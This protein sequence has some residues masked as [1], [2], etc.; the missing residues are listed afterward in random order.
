MENTVLSN[1]EIKEE[2]LNNYNLV[3]LIVDDREFADKTYWKNSNTSKR[4]VKKVGAINSNWQLE[5]TSYGSQP[6]FA[7]LSSNN[8]VSTA[9]GFTESEN[10]ILDFLK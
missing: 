3:T 5:F 9:L 8:T 7:I 4:I 10:E 6:Y 1:L 2:M